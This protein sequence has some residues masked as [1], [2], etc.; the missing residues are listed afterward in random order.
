MRISDW[1]SDV[2]SSDLTPATD[3]GPLFDSPAAGLAT[4][5][6]AYNGDTR[7]ATLTPK[8][9]T[10]VDSFSYYRIVKQEVD[11][12]A[13]GGT[14]TSVTLADNAPGKEIGRAHV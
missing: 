13:Q 10:A 6:S 5:I 12:T 11:G 2:C 7:T 14:K 9:G 4:D 1:S 8:L 3:L